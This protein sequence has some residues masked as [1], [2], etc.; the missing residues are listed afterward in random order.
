MGYRTQ[1]RA[2]RGSLYQPFSVL[3]VVFCCS[4]AVPARGLLSLSG[5][6]ELYCPSKSL[7][8][9]RLSHQFECRWWP[10]D[11]EIRV[12]LNRLPGLP[13]SLAHGPGELNQQA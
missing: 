8:G 4:Q 10:E 7:F 2:Y 12:S 6:R 3:R 9:V 5:F 11:A 1:A 13:I